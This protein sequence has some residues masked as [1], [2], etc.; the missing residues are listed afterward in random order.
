MADGTVSKAFSFRWI[1]GQCFQ[2]RFNNG[3]SL[4]TDPWYSN[5]DSGMFDHIKFPDI[6]VDDLGNVD[7]VFLNHTHPDHINNLQEVMDKYHPTV[8]TH[9]GNVLELMKAMNAVTTD[10]YPVDYEGLYYFDGFVMETH[11]ATHHSMPKRLPQTLQAALKEYPDDKR[12]TLD[13][14]GGTFNTNFV[15]TT[16]N[17]MRVAF[18]GGND[19]GMIQRLQG[20]NKPNI[21]IR[22]K[23]ASS[24]VKDNV[25]ESFAEWFAAVDTQML[26]PMHYETWLSN[27]PEFA[28]NM[29]KDMNRIM[30]EKGKAGRV[31]PM[32]RGKWYTL[33]LSI[34]PED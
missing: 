2:F 29:I 10:M 7:Y 25:A 3:I 23:M 32:I 15:L 16:D 11:H 19:D 1:N 22:N 12:A 31:A 28:E 18:I 33:N 6:T 8:I 34:V 14:M 5:D 26:I 13:W 9:S 30:E 21:I 17:G 27:D 24:A 20:P 4:L